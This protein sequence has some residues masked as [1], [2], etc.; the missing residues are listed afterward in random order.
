MDS[1]KR[2]TNARTRRHFVD[3]QIDLRRAEVRGRWNLERERLAQN[4]PGPHQRK[5]RG[6][7]ETV[8]YRSCMTVGGEV[9]QSASVRDKAAAGEAAGPRRMPA[10]RRV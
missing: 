5:A 1:A 9:P 8:I 6:H 4:A 2:G 7:K 3:R 10:E